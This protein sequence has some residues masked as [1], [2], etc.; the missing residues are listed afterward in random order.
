MSKEQLPAILSQ[1]VIA[2]S[3]LL[4]IES[5]G[6]RFSNGQER[7]YERVAGTKR[8]AVLIVPMLDADTLILI[9]EYAAGTHSYQLGFPKGL[10]DPGET[11]VE[12][13]NRELKEEVGYGAQHF[14]PLKQV[15]MNPAFFGSHMT[16]FVATS[17]YSEQ[18]EGDEPEPLVQV[19]WKLSELDTLLEHPDFTEARSIS[20]LLLMQRWLQQEQAD[21]VTL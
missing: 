14:Y 19:P 6:L 7:L 2:R 12:A 4:T 15:T 8:H 16:L 5:V 17:L 3:R 20:A 1:E 10:I 11:P 9:R 21:K 13:A 18:L